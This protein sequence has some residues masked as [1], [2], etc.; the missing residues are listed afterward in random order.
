MGVFECFTVLVDTY[1]GVWNVDK[2]VCEVGFEW[3]M[4]SEAIVWGGESW[5]ERKNAIWL[6]LHTGIRKIFSPRLSLFAPALECRGRK[7][8]SQE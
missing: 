2:E 3:L 6:Q 5:G 1:G 4:G 7:K 8:G